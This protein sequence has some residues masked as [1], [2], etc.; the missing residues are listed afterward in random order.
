MHNLPISK[1]S[2]DEKKRKE[3]IEAERSKLVNVMY[4]NNRYYVQEPWADR[5]FSRAPEVVIDKHLWL[6]LKYLPK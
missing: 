4:H 3:V 5:K 1:D 2:K 6:I